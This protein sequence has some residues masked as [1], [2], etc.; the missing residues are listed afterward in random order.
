MFA[1]QIDN[2]EPLL[3]FGEDRDRK[4][5]LEDN[6]HGDTILLQE[7]IDSLEELGQILKSI[8][9]RMLKEGYNIIN[10]KLEKNEPTI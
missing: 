7:T 3:P 2:F 6:T 5:W 8:K 10:G 9:S 1:I 4:F